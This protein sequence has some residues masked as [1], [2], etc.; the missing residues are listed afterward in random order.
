M[1]RSEFIGS[2]ETHR[3]ILLM[4][5]KHK[6]ETNMIR[7][8]IEKYAMTSSRDIVT[9]DKMLS[10]AF[11]SEILSA[12]DQICVNHTTLTGAQL[13]E[14]WQKRVKSDEHGYTTNYGHYI[15]APSLKVGGYWV[16]R[17]GHYINVKPSVYEEIA[18][19]VNN[20]DWKL[21]SKERRIPWENETVM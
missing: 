8:I 5:G 7:S 3:H 11:L 2:L 14:Q 18:L 6:L 20:V 13:I 1:F 10:R 19:L 4:M 17:P 15:S 16:I 12:Y 21:D 9:G